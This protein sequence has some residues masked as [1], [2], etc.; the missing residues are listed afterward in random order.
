MQSLYASLSYIL[1]KLL[2]K[3]RNVMFERDLKET[4]QKMIE[5]PEVLPR[6]L[7][8]HTHSFKYDF[9]RTVLIFTLVIYGTIKKK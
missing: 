7:N 5:I 6:V 8:K 2:T 3:Y 1:P 4:R 9:V